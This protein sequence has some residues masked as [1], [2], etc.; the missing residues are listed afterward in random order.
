MWFVIIFCTQARDT[1]RIMDD[2][3]VVL[4][5]NQAIHISQDL[6]AI[7]REFQGFGFKQQI[8]PHDIEI[9]KNMVN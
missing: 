4:S 1:G 8:W 6:G 9:R 3:C 2:F 5:G 7:N